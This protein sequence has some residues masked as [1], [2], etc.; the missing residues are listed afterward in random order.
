MLVQQAEI[1]NMMQ[2]RGMS[3]GTVIVVS[4]TMLRDMMMIMLVII[5]VIF[6]LWIWTKEK[7]E[8]G[9]CNI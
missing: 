3:V 2:M 8:C 9:K 1:F 6:M 5:N 4:W 7:L